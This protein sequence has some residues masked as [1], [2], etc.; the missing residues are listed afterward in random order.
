MNPGKIKTN[1]TSLLLNKVIAVS[2]G[3]ICF[4]LTL[5]WTLDFDRTVFSDQ[6]LIGQYLRLFDHVI[7]EDM[8]SCGVTMLRFGCFVVQ[9]AVLIRIRPEFVACEISY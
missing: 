5:I 6:Y 1:L 4:M 7:V 8:S 9:C 2:L 3:Y